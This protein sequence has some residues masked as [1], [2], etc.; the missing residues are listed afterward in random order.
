[1]SPALSGD[2]IQAMRAAG[3]RPIRHA[4]ATYWKGIKRL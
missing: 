2:V 4:R 1:V 3:W